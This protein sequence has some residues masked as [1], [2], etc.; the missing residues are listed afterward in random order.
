MKKLLLVLVALMAA[1]LVIGIT[2]AF[3]RSIDSDAVT[4]EGTE[5]TTA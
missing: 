3:T 4:D 1:S 2:V 5:A